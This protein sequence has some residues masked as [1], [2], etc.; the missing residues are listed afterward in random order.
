ME[1][2]FKLLFGRLLR[3][4]EA[5]AYEVDA[6]VCASVK[7]EC[8]WNY[9]T[10]K[11]IIDFVWMLFFF[12]SMLKTSLLWECIK[13]ALREKKQHVDLRI[14]ARFKV[15]NVICHKFLCL[16]SSSLHRQSQTLVSSIM[17]ST[18]DDDD[19]VWNARSDH[20]NA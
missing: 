5:L 1:Y 15:L 20:K 10:L 17:M 11:R 16:C 12:I 2:E 3:N 9:F 18:V 14:V 13:N 6:H 19:D 4:C 8:K 7:P